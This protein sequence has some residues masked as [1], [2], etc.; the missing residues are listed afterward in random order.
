MKQII[1][2]LILFSVAC[3]KTSKINN[4]VINDSSTDS[5]L[6]ISFPNGIQF[7]CSDYSVKGGALGYLDDGTFNDSV[8]I[9]RYYEI[10]IQN[11]FVLKFRSFQYISVFLKFTVPSSFTVQNFVDSTS[12]PSEL[13]I[14]D[15][16]FSS[17]HP[18]VTLSTNVNGLNPISGTFQITC[19]AD[20]LIYLNQVVAHHNN[21]IMITGTFD[22][23]PYHY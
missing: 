20:S 10:P 4:N 6:K 22:N 11:L 12:Y 19:I 21:P 13:V 7:L 3:K 23:V 16:S 15:S 17:L 1:I 18:T 2:V 5:K 14:G 8:P 9:D